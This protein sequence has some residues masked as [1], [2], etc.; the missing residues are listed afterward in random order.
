MVSGKTIPAKP[1][2]YPGLAVMAC[3][4]GSLYLLQKNDVVASPTSLFESLPV[5]VT[6]SLLG[7]VNLFNHLAGYL[8]P[9]PMWALFTGAFI[10]T[11]S[12]SLYGLVYYLIGWTPTW[13][14]MVWIFQMSIHLYYMSTGLSPPSRQAKAFASLMAHMRSLQHNRKAWWN[15]IFLY[16]DLCFHA[17]FIYTILPLN[18][19]PAL[20]VEAILGFGFYQFL[21]GRAANEGGPSYKMKETAKGN[22]VCPCPSCKGNEPFTWNCYQWLYS[23]DH[24]YLDVWGEYKMEGDQPKRVT[25]TFFSRSS[26]LHG[27]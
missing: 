4:V 25:S 21:Y 24:L 8:Q 15:T 14:V 2:V 7:L 1:T 23:I 6:L 27:F 20:V 5:I 12:S 17:A 22:L 16:F 11:F 26:S 9:V 18:T 13:L 10:D 19:L 3:F